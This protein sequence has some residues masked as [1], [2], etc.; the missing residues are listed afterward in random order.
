MSPAPSR[1]PPAPSRA[2]PARSRASPAPS[3]ATSRATAPPGNYYDTW[4]NH[5]EDTDVEETAGPAVPVPQAAGPAVRVPQTAGPQTAVPAV[6]VPAVPVPVPVQQTDQGTKEMFERLIKQGLERE[7]LLMNTNKQ[8]LDTMAKINDANMSLQD[9]M[10]TTLDDITRDKEKATDKRD[11]FLKSMF[12]QMSNTFQSTIAEISKEKTEAS[13]RAKESLDC[14][15]QRFVEMARD[16]NAA[17]SQTAYLKAIV[18][19][20]GQKDSN[21]A[22]AISGPGNSFSVTKA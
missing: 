18:D 10:R 21:V 11:D 16:N 12:D 9:K 5:D 3:R 2:S 15:S 8:L 19:L 7:S 13:H 4:D 1:P 22:F 17:A 20:N 6:P 14:V